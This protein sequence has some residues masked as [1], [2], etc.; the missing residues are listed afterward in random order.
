MSLF[1]ILSSG[2]KHNPVLSVHLL[3]TK[4]RLKWNRTSVNPL[5]VSV[6]GCRP[7]PLWRQALCSW[8]LDVSAPSF[9]PACGEGLLLHWGP[10]SW[11]ARPPV[12]FSRMCVQRDNLAPVG[13]NLYFASI[14]ES[15]FMGLRLSEFTFFS[16][17]FT[18]VIPLYFG[19]QCYW[20]ECSILG[21]FLL[22]LFYFSLLY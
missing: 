1:F 8:S 6:S 15:V 20:W 18:D 7:L 12:G 17:H 11:S 4:I 9:R 5:P 3:R 14:F 13:W 16:Q 22:R 21:Y 19:L 2:L 10:S